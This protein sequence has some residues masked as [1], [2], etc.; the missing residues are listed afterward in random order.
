VIDLR[1]FGFSQVWELDF[2]FTSRPGNRPVPLCMVAREWFSGG[3]IR[4]FQDELWR[5]VVPPFSVASDSLFMAYFA[6]AELGCFLQLGWSFPQNVVDLFFEFRNLTNGLATPAGASLLGALSYFGLN[7]MDAVEKGEMRTLAMRG[8][9]FTTT[10]QAALLAYCQ[11]D[12]MA[13]HQLS[14]CMLPKINVRQA[15]SRG[16][17]AKAIARMEDTG[18]P[19]DVEAWETLKA[20]WKNIQDELIAHVD[21]GGNYGV[22]EGRTFKTE[23]MEQYVLRN[24]IKWPRLESDKLALDDNTFR[25][26]ASAYPQIEPLRQLRQ[27]LSQ[28]RLADFSIG[29]DARNRVL[30][31]PF[32]SRTGRNQP[33]NSKFIPGA[34]SWFRTFIRPRAGFALAYVDY[35]QEE[36]GIAAKLS[37]DLAMQE[38]YCSGDPYLTLGKQ[39]GKIPP[40]GTRE[41]HGVVRDQFK[42]LTLAVQYGMGADSLAQRL[43]QTVSDARELL[44]LHRQ[45]YKKYWSWSDAVVD[46]AVLHGFLP[47]VFG[48]TIHLDPRG[49]LDSHLVRFLRN[50]P[51]QANGAEILRVACCGVTEQGIAVCAPIHD[52]LLIEAPLSDLDSVVERTQAAMVEAS[53]IVLSGFPLRVEAKLIRHPERFEDPRGAKMWS[54]VWGCMATIPSAVESNVAMVPNVA[55]PAA[56]T[57]TATVMA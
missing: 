57:S 31:S 55:V 6:P 56:T 28:M 46:Y 49:K 53:E 16:R 1:Q 32:A 47:T 34:A 54:T 17:Y 52:A 36:F 13:L 43:G 18:I 41:T 22:Y 5:C 37:S 7:V 8:G 14:N 29:D 30:L 19:V 25:V 20:N 33:S 42:T 21:G 2:E 10:E 50:F 39:A 11:G 44:R 23:R 45:T 4:L 3:I 48:W 9:P 12:V 35:E 26:M 15:L 51:M 24:R 38:A 40:C 27:S